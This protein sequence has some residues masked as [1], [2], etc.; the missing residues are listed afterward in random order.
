MRYTE[1]NY[2]ENRDNPLGMLVLAIMSPIR[3]LREMGKKLP[4]LPRKTIERC[5]L[6]SLVIGIVFI[7]VEC[8]VRAKLNNFSLYTGKMPILLQIIV[9]FL[10]GILYAFYELYSFGIY[11]AADN[12]LPK[13]T[14]QKEEVEED[15]TIDEDVELINNKEEV[16]EE[17]INLEN[18][19]LQKEKPKSFAELINSVPKIDNSNTPFPIGIDANL[20]MPQLKFEPT[21][22]PNLVKAEK[23]TEAKPDP[24]NMPVSISKLLNKDERKETVGLSKN[25]DVYSY[26]NSLDL[27]VEEKIGSD[28]EEKSYSNEELQRISKIFDDVESNDESCLDSSIAESCLSIEED[29]ALASIHTLKNWKLPEK[30]NKTII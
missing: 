12:L 14:K 5:L 7:I 25:E 16:K 30:L 8:L 26:Q 24:D 27:L 29:D 17:S 28:E 10:I 9:V 11:S 18:T 3:F 15:I 2:N 13:T 22:P 21:V 6:T 23:D 19:E 20:K 4:F 1:K